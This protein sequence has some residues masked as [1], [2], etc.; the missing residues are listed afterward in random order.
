[1]QTPPYLLLGRFDKDCMSIHFSTHFFTARTLDSEDPIL[2]AD[3]GSLSA[4]S[5]VR[6]FAAW[7]R[8]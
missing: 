6:V 5:K 3:E 8:K 7:L 1:M 4:S 2:L